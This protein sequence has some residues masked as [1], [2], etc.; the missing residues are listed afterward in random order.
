[1]RR[2]LLTLRRRMRVQQVGDLV[3]QLSPPHDLVNVLS[4]VVAIAQETRTRGEEKMGGAMPT[5]FPHLCCWLSAPRSSLISGTSRQQPSQQKYTTAMQYLT[6]R[7]AF[8]SSIQPCGRRLMIVRAEAPMKVVVT[9]AAGRTGSLVTRKLVKSPN[10]EARAVV[11][12]E[13]VSVGPEPMLEVGPT[14]QVEA[15]AGCCCWGQT[16]CSDP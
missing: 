1:M 9:G 12:S 6:H 16:G 7:P 4:S 11:R 8:R 10:F 14:C 15:R 5:L 3:S 13:S 2:R